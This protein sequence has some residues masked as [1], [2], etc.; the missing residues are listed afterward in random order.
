[1]KK[2][3]VIILVG[4][5]AVGKTNLSIELATKMNGEIISADSMQIYKY[6]DIG[7]AKISLNETK[8]IKHYLINEIFPDEAF[9]VSDFQNKAMK[10][11][12]IIIKKKKLPIIVGGTG[13]YVNSIIYDLDFSKT[14]SNPHIRK[15]YNMLANKYGNEYIHK[16]LEKIDIKSA[17]RIH[18]NDRKRIIRALEVFYVT[19]KPMSE[20]YNNF[21][22]PNEKFDLAVIGLTMNRK[23]LYE[24][25]NKRV[26]TMIENGLISEVKKLLSMGYDKSLVSMQGL[27][28]KEIIDYLN[29]KYSLEEAIEIIKRDTRRFAKRQLTWFRRESQLKWVNLDDFNSIKETAAY[30]QNYINETLKNNKIFNNIIMGEGLCEKYY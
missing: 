29:G 11:I 27:G 16:E 6:M 30:I 26:D 25:I 18:T 5:T 22:K 13:L 28:Y 21:R 23:K 9:S 24:R 10:Y 8:G 3:P 15:K 19:G 20:F 4:P 14:V 2:I 7:T 17:Q 1:M 12:D